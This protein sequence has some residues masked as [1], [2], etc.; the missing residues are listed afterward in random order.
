MEGDRP[1]KATYPWPKGYGVGTELSANL[2]W[3]GIEA[4]PGC[5]CE[6]RANR[7]DEEGIEWCSN[8]RALIFNWLKEEAEKRN[9]DPGQKKVM[10]VPM[11]AGLIIRRSISSAKKKQQSGLYVDEYSRYS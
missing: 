7:M 11:A 8:N 9:R 1:P 5:T 2:K 6:A 4:A 3:W 10:F